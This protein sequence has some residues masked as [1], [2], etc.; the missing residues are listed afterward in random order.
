MSALKLEQLLKRKN[1]Y[2]FRS[3]HLETAAEFVTAL[4]DDHVSSAGETQFGNFLEGVAIHVAEQ[5]HGG[6]KSAVKGVDLEFDV[7]GERNIV[8]IK[9]GPN[10]G[11]ASQ[12]AKMKLDFKAAAKTLRTSNSGLRIKAVNGCCYGRDDSPDKGDYF[13][14]CGQRFW[15]YLSRSDALYIDL[16]KPLGLEAKR[17]GEAFREQRVA[18]LNQFTTAFGQ[19]FCVNGPINWELLLRFNSGVKEFS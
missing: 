1:P 3:K 4:V 19:R 9:S 10:W 13:K 11:N 15:E 8:A 12:I 17:Q 7:N 6:K 5:V 14:L 16:I 2:L 18:K